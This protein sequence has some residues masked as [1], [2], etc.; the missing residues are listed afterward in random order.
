MEPVDDGRLCYRTTI[1]MKSKP[2]VTI[3]TEYL[4]TKD[5]PPVGEWL[6]PGSCGGRCR[7]AHAWA[8]S[9]IGAES[10]HVIYYERPCLEPY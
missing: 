9:I 3:V 2:I 10:L 6:G 5:W 8:V 1:T 7:K 4:T